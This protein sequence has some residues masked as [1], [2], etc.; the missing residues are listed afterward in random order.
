MIYKH[1]K[2]VWTP[3]IGNHRRKFYQV[4]SPINI[5]DDLPDRIMIREFEHSD[6]RDHRG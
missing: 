1:L 4:E 6:Y 3:N 5:L 2:N